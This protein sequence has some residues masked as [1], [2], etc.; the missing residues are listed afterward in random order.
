MRLV[1]KTRPAFCA[2]SAAVQAQEVQKQ[3]LALV[4]GRLQGRGRI[5]R[6]L[7]GKL[8]ATEW[9]ALGSVQ[10]RRHGWVSTVRMRPLTGRR[11]WH[12]PC[13]HA[14]HDDATTVNLN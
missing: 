8:C 2:L 5:E 9:C 14:A 12:H 6:T 11:A 13:G 1:A 7:D 10:S 3:Y 4:G